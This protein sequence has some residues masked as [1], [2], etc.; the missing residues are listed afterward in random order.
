M[1]SAIIGLGVIGK[2]HYDTLKN[3]GENIVAVCDVDESKLASFD[4]ERKYTDYKR[5]IEDGGIDVVHICTPHYLHADMSVFALEHDVNVLCEKPLCINYEDIAR[6]QKA[7]DESKAAFGVCFQNRFNNSSVFAKEYLKDKR[8]SFALALVLWHRDA[9][10]YATGEWRGK[11]ATEGGGVCINQAIHTL[12]LLQ[13]ILSMPQKV[14]AKAENRSL[15]G[16]I[17]VEDTAIATFFGQDYSSVFIASNT[18]SKDLPVEI[19]FVFDGNR[20]LTLYPDKVLIDGE[21]ADYETDVKWQGKTSYGNGHEKLIRN[22][23]DCVAS[24]KKFEI[25]AYE[26][27]KALKEVLAIYKSNGE[28]VLV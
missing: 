28:E 16:V 24:G 12:D 4:A 7:Q 22:F 26:A 13:W 15:Q 10:Y 17:E 1:N 8:V 18:M 21:V 3:Q 5:M 6:I 23:Y 11:K 19:R 14:C 20:V 9:A 2:V 27:A 25:D